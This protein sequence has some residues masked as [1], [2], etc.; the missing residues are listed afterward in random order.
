MLVGILNGAAIAKKPYNQTGNSNVE[1]LYLFEKDPVTWEIIGKGSWGKMKYTLSGSEFDFA[2]NGHR[3]EPGCWYSLIYYPDPW[4]GDGLIILGEAR[5]DDYG[6]VKIK[7]SVDIGDLPAEDDENYPDGAK[8]WLVLSQ[9]VGGR[10]QCMIGWNP[11][12]YLFEYSLINFDDI[13]NNR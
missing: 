9:D 10:M 11:T 3:L 4:P 8:I 7:E 13:D 12:K 6:N 1:H 2:F 5:V